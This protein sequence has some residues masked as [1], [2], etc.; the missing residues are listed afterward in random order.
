[1]LVSEMPVKMH[2]FP[3]YVPLAGALKIVL[4]KIKGLESEVVPF[5]RALGRVL[6][7]DI[8]SKVDVPPFDRSAVDG[9]AVRAADTFG[10]SELKPVKLRVVGSVE[11][12]VVSKL[13]VGKGKAVKIMTG[14]PL[15]QGA[16]A[17]VM[18]EHTRANDKNIAVLAPVTPGKNVS[19]RGEDVEADEVVLRRGQLLRP[20]DVG[21]LASVGKIRV[22][23]SR[24]PEV[25]I[26]ATGSEL[27][28]PGKRLERAEITDINS[29]S[30]AAAVESCGGLSH[31]LGIVPDRPELLRRALLRA[32]GHDIVIASGGSS[33]GEHDIMPDVID[34][35]GE[36]LF[37][38]VAIRP[39]GPTAFGIVKGKPVFALAG[40]P[41][42]SLVAFDMLVRPA[43][44]KMQGLPADRGYPRVQA[45][46]ARK[47]SS[48]LG[49]ADIVRVKVLAKG[50]ELVADPIR[51]TG[52]SVLSSMTK[53]D[54]FV[55]V[56]EDVEGLDEGS[57]V[58]VELYR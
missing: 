25:A 6:A 24:R 13:R 11:I 27:R 43:L 14:A 55:M 36:L 16:D 29:Y 10:S 26:L 9:Y 33:V 19:A 44:R 45:R 34:E 53:A 48:T 58:E 57:V 50:G 28:R 23:V 20:Q 38:G 31:R 8:I 35:L 40:F 7:E 30:L 41:V 51:V 18:V 32:I 37:H 3:H 2:G 56:P 21:M 22:Q 12:G 17:V 39:G 1:M 46:L 15:P 5:D 54:G 47:V 49:R 4:S 52:S 42:A